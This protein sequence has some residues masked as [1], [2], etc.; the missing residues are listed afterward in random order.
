MVDTDIDTGI[1]VDKLDFD[2]FVEV[3]RAVVAFDV[4]VPY[5]LGE[6]FAQLNRYYHAL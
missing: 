1:V 6:L 5:K 4:V 2:V 3:L